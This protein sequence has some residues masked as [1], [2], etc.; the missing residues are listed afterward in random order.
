MATKRRPSFNSHNPA[1][2]EVIGTYPIMSKSE[3]ADVVAHARLATA[4]WQ[5]LGF[6]GRK[7]VLLAW[8]SLIINRIDQIADLISLETGKPL[9]DAKLEVSIAVN[10]IGWAAR[11][12]ES[13]M[14][15]SFRRP[16]L[17]MAN[18]SATVERSP[19]G[20][21]GVIGPWNYPL[22]TP[23]GSISYALAA[24]NTVVFKPSEYTP[25]VGMWLEESFNEVA[26]FA[27][28]FTTITG[29]GETGSSL[30]LSGVDK[31]SFTGSTQT[32]K[33]VAAQ[34]AS[35][36]V[37]IVLE[38]GGKD[39][40]IVAADA[41]IK[42]A[43]DATMWSAMANAGQSCI[44]AER[45]YVDEKVADEFIARAIELA[46]TIHAGASGDGK[47]GPAT[48][49]SQIKVIQSHIKA[50]I[51]D[52]GTCVFGGPQSVQA[53]FVQPVILIDVPEDSTAMRVETF[54]PVII[55]NRVATMH[56][57]IDL[58]NASAYGLGASVW[59]KRKG[60]KIASQL[61][62]GMVAIN[63]TFSFA[64]IASVPFGGVKDSGSGRVHGPEG[65]LEYTFARTVV[66]TRFYLPLHFL[67]FK[68][69]PQDDRLVIKLTKLLKGRLG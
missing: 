28:I 61:Q 23:A 40:V 64:A 44:A 31:I 35:V 65:L 2:E 4:Q 30:C 62:C 55:I 12:A 1:T 63:S 37:P 16:G 27:D 32:A 20:V 10:H 50:A 26:P 59:S 39:P 42:R 21:I 17:L 29:L 22:F 58:S 54:G 66:R 5:G 38:C 13:I 41:D 53:P 60:K 46:P 11:H 19:L 56:E 69:R 34:C 33:L 14:R 45:V 3:V 6:S 43:V 18:M 24:G 57:A 51:A 25:G 48:M 47:Y 67:S 49:P 52:G 68:R 9:S 7:R 8:S 15:T 36:M